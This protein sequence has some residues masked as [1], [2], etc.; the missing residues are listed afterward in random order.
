MSNKKKEPDFQKEAHL[1]VLKTFAGAV[2]WLDEEG[3]IIHASAPFIDLFSLDKK[4]VEGSN[5]TDIDTGFSQTAFDQM[6]N[7]LCQDDFADWHTTLQ[8]AGQ[9]KHQVLVEGRIVQNDLC[10]FV[11]LRVSN[12]EKSE[13][14]RQL[15]NILTKSTKSAA[16]K[17]NLINGNFSITDS[18]FHLFSIPIKK[19][20]DEST[21]IIK[22]LKPLLSWDQFEELRS[23]ILRLGEQQKRLTFSWSPII[24]G[25]P[26]KIILDAFPTF[27]DDKRIEI[28]GTIRQ[29]DRKL[30]RE[31]LNAIAS[32]A[33]EQSSNLILI[34]DED[35]NI[36]H[37][38]EF[39]LENLDLQKT[40]LDNGLSIFKVD[41]EQ[42]LGQW[43]KNLKKLQIEKNLSLVTS[44]QRKEAT[45]FPVELN[46]IHYQDFH[47]H[48]ICIIGKDVSENRK[49]ESFLKSKLIDQTSTSRQLKEKSD[50]LVNES[51]KHFKLDKIVSIS[52]KYQSVLAKVKQVA[53]TLSTVLIEGETGTGKELV[54]RAIHQ[55]SSQA[56]RTMI[57]VNCGN[58]PKELIESELLGHEE[59]A[60]AGAIE[61]KKGR[62]ELADKST[63]FLDEI[64]EMPMQMQTRLLRVMQEGNLKRVG[65]T[66]TIQVDIRIIAATNQNLKA[67]VKEGTF[68]EDL[69]YR[70]NVFPI[71]NIPLRERK[72]DVKLLAYHFLGLYNKKMNRQ[73]RYIEKND[74]ERLIAY[75]FPGNIRELENI[76][77]HSVI[78]TTGATLS[79]D[80]WQQNSSSTFNEE[81]KMLIKKS[82]KTH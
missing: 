24:N 7:K 22:L 80:S 47:G 37:A 39:A 54:A 8:F 58:I 81:A 72:E 11:C 31:R 63:L 73:I 10:E 59:G 61:Q 51:S 26:K 27:K 52:K 14:Q 76:I 77:E 18:F 78:L 1:K 45:I 49:K 43:K 33:L 6:W 13:T 20:E 44:F 40:D 62:F 29:A 57:K 38:N 67:M 41:I 66:E 53:P 71:Y 4:S 30:K 17:W 23:K 55:L 16:W 82:Q 36:V 2:L 42:S 64:G 19:Y 12:I 70:L 5:W 25:V 75:D 69:Y 28:N 74:L 9:K 32:T 68:R 79:L 21:N 35:F 15:L 48:L 65:G 46:V 56:N 34:I 60:F 3:K 50:Y